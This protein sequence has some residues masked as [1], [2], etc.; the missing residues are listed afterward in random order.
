MQICITLA[1]SRLGDLIKRAQNGEEI[2]LTRQGGAAV[3]LSPLKSRTPPSEEQ[4]TISRKSNRSSRKRA[5]Q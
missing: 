3:R 2:I 4:Q 1:R 5:P